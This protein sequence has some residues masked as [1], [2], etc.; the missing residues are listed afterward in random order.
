MVE[1]ALEQEADLRS[2]SRTDPREA[3][4][5]SLGFPPVKYG[6][7]HPPPRRTEFQILLDAAR[8]KGKASARLLG[9]VAADVTSAPETTFPSQIWKS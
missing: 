1:R 3:R 7:L 9:G 6:W 5:P 2:G 8:G 4:L